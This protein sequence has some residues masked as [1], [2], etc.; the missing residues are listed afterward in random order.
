MLREV[1][2]VKPN[3]RFEHLHFSAPRMLFRLMPVQRTI[4]LLRRTDSVAV[5]PKTGLTKSHVLQTRGND[6]STPPESRIIC[7]KL[8][9]IRISFS[10][11]RI[12]SKK[13]LVINQPSTVDHK[14]KMYCTKQPSTLR[15][16][17]TVDENS[18]EISEL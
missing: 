8:C 1:E 9:Y 15:Q 10:E 6:D 16:L 12:L 18:S 2:N 5:Y 14:N 7:D 4:D 3:S 17:R 13:R 11:P